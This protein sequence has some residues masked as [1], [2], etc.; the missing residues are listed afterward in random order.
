MHGKYP[1]KIRQAIDC[2]INKQDILNK[3]YSGNGIVNNSMVFPGYP[4]YTES[5]IYDTA[6]AAQLVKEAIAEGDWSADRTLVIG[7][8]SA[9]GENTAILLKAQ[10]AEIGI[11]VEI[12]QDEMATIQNAMIVDLGQTE[13]YQYDAAIWTV[14]AVFTPTKML[15]VYAMYS[16]YLFFH[17]DPTEVA[18]IYQSYMAAQDAATE[19]AAVQA[20]QAWELDQVPQSTLVQYGAYS[21]TAPHIGNVDLFNVSNFNQASWLWTVD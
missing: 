9:V 4:G 1:Q 13:E 8:V 12:K 20:F 6:K 2:G 21:A 19:K 17:N 15:N 16:N 14:G 10:L 11:N 18:P 3:I 5:K 7:V